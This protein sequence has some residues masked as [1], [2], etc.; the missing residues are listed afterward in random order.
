[1]R[2]IRSAYI[3]V[4]TVATLIAA[5]CANIG[6]P[7][8][9]PYDETPPVIVNTTP[10]YGAAKSKATKI[11]LEFDEN[12]KIE[13]ASEKIIVSPPQIEQPEISALGKKITVQL[14]DSVK[15]NVTYTIDFSD[16][17]EDNNEGNPMGDY[18]FTF[19]TGD[20]IDTMQVSGYVLD[21]SNLEPVKGIYVGLYEA[22][23]SIAE[24]FP[25]SVFKTKPFDRISRTDS[26]GHFVVKGLNRGKYRAYALKD[27]DQ[28][29]SYTQKSEMLAFN[30]KVIKS[31][32]KPDIR[33]DTIWHDS[34]HY[35]SIVPKN[36][37]HF[38]PDDIVLLAF[39]EKLTDH[40]FLKME[41]PNL[42]EFTL[43]YT[44]PA[45]EL[46][47][48][49]G[50]NF[51]SDNAFVVEPNPTNDTIKYWILDSLI[52]NLDTLV[53]DLSY[54]ATDSL[55]KLVLTTDSATELISKVT[56]A[57]VDK[58]KQQAYEEWVKDYKDELKKKKKK[59]HDEKDDESADGEVAEELKS[60]RK[61]KSKDEDIEIPPMPEEFLEVRTSNSSISPVQNMDFSSPEPIAAIDTALFHF[62]EKID[63]VYVNCNF[64]IRKRDYPH[65]TYR[66]YAEWQPG[67]AYEITVD[68]G[69][70]VS[71]YGKRSESFVK[72]VKVR[73]AE[74]F[75]SVFI[76][77]HGVDTCAVVELLNSSDKPVKKVK[78]N[79]KTKAEFYYVDPGTYYL[80]TFCDKNGNGIWDTG[81]YDA[82]LQAEEVYY[83]PRSFVVRANWDISQEWWPKALPVMKQKPTAI[84]KQKAD[85]EKDIRKKNADR[86]KEKNKK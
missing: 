42:R 56:K 17:I 37:T 12:I 76:N 14:I 4:L 30:D 27:Q 40:Y 20:S 59:R 86:L 33:Y 47:T 34:I 61:K 50:I 13:N 85:K 8:G 58:Q 48:I 49:N 51:N 39:T 80:R 46:P 55:G 81:S 77:L 5:A 3:A 75:G 73:S 11:V 62:R 53:F 32:C 1:M 74:S 24:E 23:D 35:D 69:A 2:K 15:P 22:A 68:T 25:D 18:A 29:Y 10:K 79:E 16:A 83:Y 21:A 45:N 9:G 44:S 19:S 66:F 72:Q 52:Y 67:H 38:Y 26:R 78:V 71:V 7:D 41:R 70:F 60:K 57:K 6:S 63:S 64:K 54:M 31:T 43:F 82:H 65:N 28:S 36:Y 84:T